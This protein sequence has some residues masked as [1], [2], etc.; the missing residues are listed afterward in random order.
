MI[1]FNTDGD[2]L[3]SGSDDS[4]I[5]IWRTRDG[6]KMGVCVGKGACKSF[7]VTQDSDYILASYVTMGV[8][9]YRVHDVSGFFNK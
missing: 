5:N 2:L 9:I 3:F 8:I 4:K 1:K 6:E 7:D